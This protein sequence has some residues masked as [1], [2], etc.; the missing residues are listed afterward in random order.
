[1]DALWKSIH[2]MWRHAPFMHLYE[3]WSSKRV[4]DCLGFTYVKIETSDFCVCIGLIYFIPLGSLDVMEHFHILCTWNH[5]TSTDVHVSIVKCT[6]WEHWH[7]LQTPGSKTCTF[8]Y[9]RRI[10]NIPYTHLDSTIAFLFNV[11]GQHY[12]LAKQKKVVFVLKQTC[13]PSHQKRAVG[14]ENYY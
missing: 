3:G 7:Y 5:W 6:K 9:L 8:E 1:M 4:Q 12:I 2:N 14:S 13:N 11:L 10:C